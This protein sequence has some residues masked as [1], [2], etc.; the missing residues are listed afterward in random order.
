MA[1][2]NKRSCPTK[3][4]EVVKLNQCYIF[5]NFSH[6]LTNI[7]IQIG[8]DIL[9]CQ[10]SRDPGIYMDVPNLARLSAQYWESSISGESKYFKLRFVSMRSSQILDNTD[11][12]QKQI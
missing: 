6:F 8:S 1:E 12:V 9:R 4:S 10:A 5:G 2:N 7:R 11:T 3:S